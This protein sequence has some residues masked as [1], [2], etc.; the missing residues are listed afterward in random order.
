[1]APSTRLRARP[2]RRVN[3][4][5]ASGP[6]GT[7]RNPIHIEES[8]EP[9]IG[10]RAAPIPVAPARKRGRKPAVRENARGASPET[11][12]ASRKKTSK[13]VA[14]VKAGA[15]VKPKA[16]PKTRKKAPTPKKKERPTKQECSICANKKDTTRSFKAPDDACEHLHGICNLCVAKMLK[17]KV[18]DRQLKQA[19][20]SCPVPECDHS[21]DYA[22]LQAIVSKAAFEE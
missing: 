6:R 22:G 4:A 3:Y 12:E 15:V 7:R 18:A 20:L 21:L 8:P 11:P 2:E 9:E 10:S 1:M 14:R 19:E 5:E 13:A 16:E 17:T